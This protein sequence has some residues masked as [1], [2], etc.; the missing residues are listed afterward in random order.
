MATSSRTNVFSLLALLVLVAI[1]AITPE[2]RSGAQRLTDW[3]EGVRQER[4]EIKQREA[5]ERAKELQK[6]K[7][8][9][10]AHAENNEENKEEAMSGMV[11][12]E[13]TVLDAEGKYRPEPGYVWYNDDPANFDVVWTPGTLHPDTPRVVASSSPDQWV[14]APG[15]EWVE[16]KGVNDMRVTWKPG[17]VHSRFEHVLAAQN[18]GEWTPDAKYMWAND[19]PADLTVVP[20]GQD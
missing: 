11:P 15:Y 9:E 17:K 19:D 7:E 14:P 5:E 16:E 10:L 1:V 18:E 6:I 2:A 13:H 8:Q 4:A 20:I 3:I 12:P